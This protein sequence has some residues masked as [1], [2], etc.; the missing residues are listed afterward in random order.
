M[1]E[2]TLSD[3]QY[4][5]KILYTQQKLDGKVIAKKI[6]VSE[7]TIS[8]W[9]NKFNWKTLRNRLA[10]GKDE[11]LNNLYNQLEELN[12]AIAQRTCGERFAN[13]K[14]ADIFVKYTAAIRNLETDLAIA[15]ISAS[16]IKFI[17]YLQNVAAPDY[18]LQVAESWNDFIQEQI[19]SSK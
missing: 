3:K 4:L 5:A 9:V 8:K 14:E 15:D 18:V 11:I 19:K 2:I 13:T 16:G 17:K 12:E 6:G 1:A 7:N 10:V